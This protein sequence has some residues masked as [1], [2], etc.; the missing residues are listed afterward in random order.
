M[1]FRTLLFCARGDDCEP[2]HRNIIFSK[3]LKLI[4][5]H[6]PRSSRSEE[7]LEMC[8]ARH[9]EAEDIKQIKVRNPLD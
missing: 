9:Q 1:I 5:A 4:D 7:W 2:L 6:M 8:S 3:S